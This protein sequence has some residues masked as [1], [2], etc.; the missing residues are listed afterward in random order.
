MRATFFLIAGAGLLLASAC[1]SSSGTPFGP[2]DGGD[3]GGATGLGGKGG[4]GGSSGGSLGGGPSAGG[5]SG[6]TAEDGGGAVGGAAG[7]GGQCLSKEY[8]AT[9]RPLDLYIMLDRSGSMADRTAAGTT[10]WDAVTAALTSFFTAEQ[11][12]GLGVGLQYFPL[13]K[14]GVPET[15]TSNADCGESGP[16]ALRI[17]Y[18]AQFGVTN[19]CTSNTDCGFFYTCTDLGRCSNN[20]SRDC[21][22]VGGSCEG[23]EGSCVKATS[24]YCAGQT[25]CTIAD[26]ARP[27]V[28]IR[29]L[30]GN[31]QALA[32]SIA[33]TNPTGNTPTSAAL[34]GAIDRARTHATENP[35]RAVS[36]LFAT[37]GLPTACD[38]IDIAQIRPIAAQ[39][40]AGTPSIPTFVIGVFAANETTA[41]QNLDAL[42]QSGGTG[43]A[44]MVDASGNVSQQFLAALDQ[45]RGT[46]LACE[47]VLPALEGGLPDFDK[48]EVE[49]VSSAGVQKVP[50][51]AKPEDCTAANGGWYFDVDPNS[52]GTPSTVLFCPSTCSLFKSLTAPSVR[53][54]AS[55]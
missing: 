26:Y 15:C 47:F 23:A 39:A 18:A 7:D 2:L 30:P 4:A 45:I 51:V 41:Q 35:A 16:C 14:A 19:L 13:T 37:D 46:A 44:F 40:F 20:P 22:P 27:A 6:G 21:L 54:R 24:S 48:L 11:S 31:A 3:A 42:A 1:G 29:A 49:V 25:S 33:K 43:S 52:G 28:D 34:S 36:V 38:P 9:Q 10:K 12:N 55:C 17:C 8:T 32:S 5:S 53:I 50:R